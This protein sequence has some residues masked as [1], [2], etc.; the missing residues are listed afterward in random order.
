MAHIH[1]VYDSDIHFSINPVTRTIK[2]ESGKVTLIQ[3]DH[4]SERFTFEI[5]RKVEEHDMS[6]CNKVQVHFINIDSSTKE[7][8]SDI[9][10]VVDLQISPESDDVVICSWLV[11]GNATRF[12]G[13]LNFVIRFSCVAEDGT[14]EYAWNTAVHS[15]ISVS[16]GI[17]N[18]DVIYEEHFDVLEQWKAELMADLGGNVTVDQTFDPESLNAQSGVAVAEAIEGTVGNINSILETLVEGVG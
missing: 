6:L 13:S 9:Y 15:G 12:V 10:E 3:H 11:S 18:S 5:P 7:K 14:I 2:N 17:Y 16:S 1:S 8:H 4:N